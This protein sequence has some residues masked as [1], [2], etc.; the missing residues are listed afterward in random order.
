[1][2]GNIFDVL[3]DDPKHSKAIRGYPIVWL[4]G[5]V[6][7]TGEWIRELEEYVKQGGTLV[8]GSEQMRHFGKGFLGIQPAGGTTAAEQWKPEG[9]AVYKAVP[10]DLT[11]VK[12]EGAVVLAW[13]GEKPLI[14]RQA[15]GKGAVIVTLVPGM[16]GQDERAHP[17]LPWLMNGLTQKLLPVEVRRPDGSPVVGEILYQVN[18]TRTGYLVLLMNNQG[19]DKTQSG[20]A[21][22]DRRKVVDV[23]VRTE[24]AVREVREWTEPRELAA[25]K[26]KGSTSIPIRV[27]PGDVQVVGFVVER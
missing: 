22:V 6:E 1:V 20:V 18:R 2:Y 7:P 12:R 9:G 17:A 11:E 16:L 19:V 8:L 26:D 25:K 23:V 10:F 21:R 15:V 4:A 13:T 24:L 5:D 3:V 27:H 14:T